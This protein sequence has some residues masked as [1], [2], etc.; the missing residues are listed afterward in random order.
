MH[1][2]RCILQ[3][4]RDPFVY[5]FYEKVVKYKTSG[6]P[7][8]I[9]EYYKSLL[10]DR[11]LLDPKTPGAG[12]RKQYK[13]LTVSRHARISSVNPKLGG[14]LAA[15]VS[16]SKPDVIIELGTSFGISTMYMAAANPGA[17]LVTVEGNPGIAAIASN[18][19]RSGGFHN[20][21]L[22][23]CLFDDVINDLTQMITP[24]C[25][26]FI[27]GNH[28]YD[29]TVKYYK[30]F[31]DARIIVFDDIRWSKEMMKA[32]RMITKLAGSSVIIDLFNTG[33][34]L[35]SGIRKKY[36]FRLQGSHL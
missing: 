18:G 22:R 34:I 17:R 3:S 29:A 12:T 6:H 10:N 32:W 26:V 2:V 21:E 25:M 36:S 31:S 4:K 16:Y 33:I 28:R 11:S 9:R 8:V 20:I 30:H 15:L 23:N 5:E 19:F 7:P 24:D 13:E 27:D 1:S 35:N 14:L